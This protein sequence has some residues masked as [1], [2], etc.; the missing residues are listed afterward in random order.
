MRIF[1]ASGVGSFDIYCNCYLV[2]DKTLC[3]ILTAADAMPLSMAGSRVDRKLFQ[4]GYV[5]PP[6]QPGGNRIWSRLPRCDCH[7]IPIWASSGPKTMSSVHAPMLSRYIH[8]PLN[9]P[10]GPAVVLVH[11][12]TLSSEI[13]KTLNSLNGP[14]CDGQWYPDAFQRYNLQLKIGPPSSN[15]YRN[16]LQNK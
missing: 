2:G 10:N 9:L 13:H 16:I 4:H 15:S 8:V 6:L 12:P 3:E 11:T 7:A 5:R 14:A 1:S